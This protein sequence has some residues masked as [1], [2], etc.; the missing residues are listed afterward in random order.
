MA[1]F[2]L[3]KNHAMKKII[4]IIL[5]VNVILDSFMAV[6]QSTIISDPFLYS[7]IDRMIRNSGELNKE[8]LQK[9]LELDASIGNS[10]G[11][12]E[13]RQVIQSLEGL[14]YALNIT[15]L[16]LSGL[17]LNQNEFISL[18]T[19]DFSPLDGLPE[20]GFLDLSVNRVAHLPFKRE[21]PKLKHLLLNHNQL[22]DLT[23]LHFM[24]ALVYLN[25]DNNMV[26]NITIPDH[27]TKLR[28]LSAA[29]NQLMTIS[30]PHRLV[31]WP[32]KTGP[33]VKLN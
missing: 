13:R 14:Q 11:R 12:P 10:A 17:I 30:L 16:N 2:V 19:K 3:D 23:F 7:L 20:L 28:F 31:R 24:P 5:S 1:Y 25:L 4:I 8:H 32:R 33:D 26:S 21:F 27:L 18:E 15:S 6:A 22:S 29:S 9:L